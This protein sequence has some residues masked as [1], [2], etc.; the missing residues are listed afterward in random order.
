MLLLHKNTEVLPA[1]GQSPPLENLMCKIQCFP[2]YFWFIRQPYPVLLLLLSVYHM[3]MS[4]LF[5]RE[6][7]GMHL[8]AE[9]PSELQQLFF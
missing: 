2:A 6:G 1:V 7:W 8:E 5:G 3:D 9:H 4:L